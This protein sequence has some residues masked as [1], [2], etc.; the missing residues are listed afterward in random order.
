MEEI[1]CISLKEV[2][3]KNSGYIENKS[4]IKQILR[5]VDRIYYSVALSD[6]LEEIEKIFDK[7]SKEK[8][9]ASKKK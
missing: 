6:I 7:Q 9:R 4:L 1:S 3:Y 5:D 8:E 2:I